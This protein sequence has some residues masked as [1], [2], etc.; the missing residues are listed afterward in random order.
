MAALYLL[1]LIAAF[2]TIDHELLLRLER[3]FG[4]R[5]SSAMVR[6]LSVKQIFSGD[7]R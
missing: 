4:L 1:D 7:V 3:P 2:D 5:G 6:L